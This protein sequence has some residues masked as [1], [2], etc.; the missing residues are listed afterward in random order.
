V[1]IVYAIESPLHYGGGVSVLAATLIE[2]FAAEHEIILV[3]PDRAESLHQEPLGKKISKH[4]PW[5]CEKNPPSK[6]FFHAS[7]KAL[8]QIV[9]AKPDLVH[10]HSGGI[11]SWGNRWPGAGWPTYLH[12]HGIPTLWTDHLVVN[13][14]HGYCGDRKPFWL[15]LGMLPFGYLGK[16]QQ[17]KAVSAEICVSDHDAARLGRWYFPFQK[18]IIRVYH[19]RLEENQVGFPS[20]P[21][22]KIILAVGHLAYRK[23]QHILVQAFAKIAY[24]YPDWN[25]VLVGPE[26]PDGCA[27]WIREFCQ[28]QKLGDR[29]ALAGSQENAREWMKRCAIYVQP[30]LQEALGL[31]LQE[32]M[33]VGC[34]CIGTKVGGIP[35]LIEAGM[36]GV[37]TPPNQVASL[38]EVLSGL[39]RDEA[40]RSIL[41]RGAVQKVRELKMNRESMV[42]AY[43]KLYLESAARGSF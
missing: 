27:G 28:K 3:S 10:F 11:F 24:N 15:K 21:R 36:S 41:G 43:R 26:S 35:E 13:L 25:L 37:L 16:S 31:A 22:E 33:S 12:K 30:S 5:V 42:K 32:A 7:K 20:S 19:S 38:S 1:R 6:Y 2:S 34:A 29:V 17:L 23:G 40:Q 8:A 18:K 4:I 39:V 14:F 9:P